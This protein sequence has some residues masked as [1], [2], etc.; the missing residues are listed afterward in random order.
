MHQISRTTNFGKRSFFFSTKKNF[1]WLR[2]KWFG[3]H[4]SKFII[5]CTFSPVEGQ[6]SR[7][8]VCLVAITVILETTWLSAH[9]KKTD[10]V[11]LKTLLLLIKSKKK[12]DFIFFWLGN[13]KKKKSGIKPKKDDSKEFFFFLRND[14]AKAIQV[15]IQSFL[16][17]LMFFVKKKKTRKCDIFYES[18]N[19]R[20]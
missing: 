4:S 6:K 7:F 13:S 8:Q 14:G 19:S 15:I 18:K 16:S 5:D 9:K 2:Q 11:A 10:F 1:E 3:S 20:L 12:L 17:S